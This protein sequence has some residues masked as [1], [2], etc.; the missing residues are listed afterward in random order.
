MKTQV[1]QTSIKAYQELPLARQQRAIMD[2]FDV[3]HTSCIADVACYLNW[4]KS[5]VA[6]RINELRNAGRLILV[7]EFKSRA[8]GIKSKFYRRPAPTDY[9][10]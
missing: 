1:A 6:A 8:T 3:L 5:T 9:M 2:V 4:E 10:Y 7:G